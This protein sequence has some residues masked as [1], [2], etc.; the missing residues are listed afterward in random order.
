MYLTQQ[1]DYGLR[2]LIYLAINQHKLVK[3]SSI[4]KAYDISGSHLMKVVSY[5]VK[6]GFVLGIRGKGGGLKLAKEPKD[7]IIGEVIR[8]MEPLKLVECLSDNK[9]KAHSCLIVEHCRLQ[10]IIVDATEVFINYLCQYS[11]ADIVNEC[12]VI[13]TLKEE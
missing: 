3:I 2:V 12:D 10:G 13:Y 5:L 6:G 8:H 9:E 11:L 1:T 4:A 7:I